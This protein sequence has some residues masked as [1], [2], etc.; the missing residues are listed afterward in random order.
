MVWIAA[1]SNV[2]FLVKKKKKKSESVESNSKH[3]STGYPQEFNSL[4]SCLLISLVLTEGTSRLHWEV[5]L[6]CNTFF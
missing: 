3:S 4:N 1:V 5:A 6:L 2:H